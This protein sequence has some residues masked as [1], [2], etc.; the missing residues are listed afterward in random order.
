M[1]KQQYPELTVGGLI[2]NPDGKLLLIR[3][4][5]W[6]DK[7]VMPGGHIKLGEKIEDALKRE[8]KEETG[9]DV[10]GIEFVCL[11]EFVNN[12]AFWKK[13]H[14]IFLDFACK[15]KSTMVKLN[16]EGQEYLWIPL[17]KIDKNFI[18]PYTLSAI[19]KYKNLHKI[20]S[21]RKNLDNC[22]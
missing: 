8:L 18:E 15:A 21:G 16:D 4:H 6:K 11:L 1:I 5:K 19:N 3:S 20:L 22:F 14:F 9:L 13:R 10:Y 12:P 17:D 2:F 7:F